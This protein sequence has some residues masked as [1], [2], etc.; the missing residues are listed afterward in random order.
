MRSGGSFISI[1]LLSSTASCG[2][3][4]CRVVFTAGASAAATI[5]MSSPGQAA[6]ATAATSTSLAFL[7]DILSFMK[8]IITLLSQ[9]E[10]EEE[11][12]DCNSINS[13]RNEAVTPYIRQEPFNSDKRHNV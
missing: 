13:E 1:F 8:E 7:N 11:N 10:A 12:R 6:K 9:E 4:I 2:V 3:S 5:A